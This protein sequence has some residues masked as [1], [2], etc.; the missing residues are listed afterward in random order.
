MTRNMQWS[1]FADTAQVRDSPRSGS[2]TSDQSVRSP[3]FLVVLAAQAAGKSR[4]LPPPAVDHVRVPVMS[5]CKTEK[6]RR[7]VALFLAKKAP[8]SAGRFRISC[9]TGSRFSDIAVVVIFLSP[10]GCV[11]PPDYGDAMRVQ[12]AEHFNAVTDA[13]A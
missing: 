3:W 8:A 2:L 9:S 7:C 5:A 6:R 1:L 12:L 13:Q 10:D 4:C 11:R